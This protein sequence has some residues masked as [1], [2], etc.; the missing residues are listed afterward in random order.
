MNTMIKI[1]PFDTSYETRRLMVK[2]VKDCP[3][4]GRCPE[5]WVSSALCKTNGCPLKDKSIFFD[6]WQVRDGKVDDND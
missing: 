3:F 4:C 5:I 2:H 6:D 1:D